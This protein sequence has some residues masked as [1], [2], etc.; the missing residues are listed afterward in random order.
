MPPG[1]P[2]PPVSDL[3]ADTT[4]PDAGELVASGWVPSSEAA[5]L[6]GVTAHHVGWLARQGHLPSS[7]FRGR[8]RWLLRSE[9]EAHM[10]EQA[11]W[12][13]YVGAAAIIGCSTTTV[14][15]LARVGRITKR[16]STIPWRASLSRASVEQVAQQRARA[17][18]DLEAHRQAM[19]LS[20]PPGDDHEWISP[21]KA[22][23]TLGITTKGVHWLITHERVPA[24][25]RGARWWLRRD[26]VRLV[27]NA[28]A[29]QSE[30]DDTG[31]SW[32][33][34]LRSSP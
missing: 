28:R 12:V 14:A 29:A 3:P 20:A 8:Q 16:D 4:K 19:S 21:A 13:S 33:R 10:A 25:R 31:R 1:P 9:I 34:G 6:L 30:R 11:R 17:A 7:R 27:A 26:L 24:E 23:E 2:G 5:A 18:D 15:T 22:A 32:V